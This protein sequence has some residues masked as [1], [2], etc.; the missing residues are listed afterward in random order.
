MGK[1]HGGSLGR[2]CGWR[3]IGDFCIILNCGPV[4]ASAEVVFEACKPL[5]Y[6]TR[7]SLVASGPENR[8][9]KPSF[10]NVYC[11]F[12]K[13]RGVKYPC[14]EFRLDPGGLI[15]PFPYRTKQ[16]FQTSLK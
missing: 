2:A 13:S 8:E 16:A 9:L 4:T 14:P 3:C 1:Y 5:G 6:S 10:R 7:L 15:I 12:G 11:V